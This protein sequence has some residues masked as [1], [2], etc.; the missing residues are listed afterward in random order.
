M[1]TEFE[2][3]A[4]T[5]LATAMVLA[6]EDLLGDISPLGQLLYLEQLGWYVLRSFTGMLSSDASAELED[7]DPPVIALN[8]L[9]VAV[10]ELDQICVTMGILPTE[11]QFQQ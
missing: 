7:D 3:Q 9:T 8:Q 6:P 10:G 1:A 11:A 2:D 5:E 4:R